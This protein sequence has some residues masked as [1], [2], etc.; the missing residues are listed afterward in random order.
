MAG[1]CGCQAPSASWERF[2]GSLV[3]YRILSPL[4][5]ILAGRYRIAG[6]VGVCF[7]NYVEN[8]SARCGILRAW[9][10]RSLLEAFASAPVPTYGA[11]LIGGGHGPVASASFQ[12]VD[13]PRNSARHDSGGS[14]I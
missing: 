10:R 9:W 13:P 4:C 5:P 11:D 14:H 1:Q 8:L 3:L 6:V 7:N 12:Q 2:A